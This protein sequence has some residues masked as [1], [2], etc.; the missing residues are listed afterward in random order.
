MSG[1]SP[2]DPFWVPDDGASRPGGFSVYGQHPI[3]FAVDPGETFTANATVPAHSTQEPG[4]NVHLDLNG[5]AVRSGYVPHP[6]DQAPGTYRTPGVAG[7]NS[8]FGRPA[9][10]PAESP[11]V[12]NPASFLHAREGGTSAEIR[13]SRTPY[14][15]DPF[16]FQ[17][18]TTSPPSDGTPAA[19]QTGQVAI[20]DSFIFPASTPHADDVGTSTETHVRQTPFPQE[21]FILHP[22]TASDLR[23]GTTTATQTGQVALP[24]GPFIFPAS[25]PIARDMGTPT[26]THSRQSSFLQEPFILHPGAASQSGDETTAATQLGPAAIPQDPF[27]FPATN[28]LAR[29]VGTPARTHMREATVPENPSVLHPGTVQADWRLLLDAQLARSNQE[30]GT[31]EEPTPVNYQHLLTPQHAHMNQNTCGNETPAPAGNPLLPPPH[32]HYLEKY[33]TGGVP[34]PKYVLRSGLFGKGIPEDLMKQ[35]TH[36]EIAIPENTFNPFDLMGM[37]GLLVRKHYRDVRKMQATLPNNQ[38]AVLDPNMRNHGAVFVAN[39]NVMRVGAVLNGNPNVE[40]D[41]AVLVAEPRVKSNAG[42]LLTRPNVKRN[43][44]V[45]VA[46]PTRVKSNAGGPLTEPN[47]NRNRDTLVAEPNIKSNGDV[48]VSEPNI[49]SNGDILVAEPKVKS[50]GDVHV[51]E[52][53]VKSEGDNL[54]AEPN[55]RSGSGVLDTEPNINTDGA[56]PLADHPPTMTFEDY[57]WEPYLSGAKPFPVALIRHLYDPKS[58]NLTSD[59]REYLAGTKPVP[60]FKFTAR[61]CAFLTP[62]L[63]KYHRTT[64]QTTGAEE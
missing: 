61:V 42:V 32:E 38:P 4:R 51:A 54:V 11:F 18:W 43:G 7:P 1:D 64:S 46:E 8:T 58:V 52:P 57:L 55:I 36:R 14:T 48:L 6:N 50:N 39:P 44:D 9:P 45:L 56:I 10:L 40:H 26:G 23:D 30:T 12:F 31:D 28:P 33:I 16:F 27:V 63:E 13:W 59:M 5:P 37:R 49:K 29:D 47:V 24:Q 15:Q 21:P 19:T 60:L 34:F 35:Y 53:K 2:F 41:R 62:H 3:P 22:G 17:S 25:T 20:Q